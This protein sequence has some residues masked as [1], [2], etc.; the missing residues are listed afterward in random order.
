MNTLT[1]TLPYEHLR[2]TEPADLEIHEV[3]MDASLSTETSLT[4]ESIAPLNLEINPGKCEHP[5]QV[6]D[7]NLDGQVPPNGIQPTDL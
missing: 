5:C 1:Q 4:T 3:T 6:E 7:L 2:R